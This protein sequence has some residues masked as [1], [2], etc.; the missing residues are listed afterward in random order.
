[1]SVSG[2]TS[3]LVAL[4]ATTTTSLLLTSVPLF[5]PLEDLARFQNLFWP[6]ELIFYFE[7][8]LQLLVVPG[9]VRVR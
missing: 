1:M 7:L 5:L 4:A 8:L 3:A 6:L 9:P 2:S